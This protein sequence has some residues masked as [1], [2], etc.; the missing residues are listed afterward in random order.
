MKCF[1]HLL[2][3]VL[4]VLWQ[5][6]AEAGVPVAKEARTETTS[7]KPRGRPRGKT[8]PAPKGMEPI[9][10]SNNAGGVGGNNAGTDA[11]TATYSLK[12]ALADKGINPNLALLI[13]MAIIMLRF[14]LVRRL[15]SFK[16][17]SPSFWGMIAIFA[18]AGVAIGVFV[19]FDG[20][21]PILT[22]IGAVCALLHTTRNRKYD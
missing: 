5:L 15:E 1:V 22:C 16:W 21:C 2:L 11:E 17:S 19:P 7:T 20:I 4:L 9:G 12:E 10:T 18:A 14:D 3:L 6:P 8:L 13:L